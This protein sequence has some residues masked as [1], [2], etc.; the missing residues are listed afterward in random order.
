MVRKCKKGDRKFESKCYKKVRGIYDKRK[1]FYKR[2]KN[3][4][5]LT[6]GKMRFS[7]TLLE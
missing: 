7:H 1:V 2:G 4:Y 3:Y 6:K 5:K